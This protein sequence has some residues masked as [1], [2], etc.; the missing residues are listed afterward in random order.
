[1]SNPIDNNPRIPGTNLGGTTRSDGPR[2]GQGQTT[3]GDAAKSVQQGDRSVE[4]ERLQALRERVDNTGE[5]DRERVDA[6]KERI[7]NGEYVVD[8]KR[9]A[10]KF[11]ELEGLLN[12]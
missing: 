5:V 11:A 12:D 4:S 3:G 7:A 8:P 2:E 6:L 1:M 9:V 10:A